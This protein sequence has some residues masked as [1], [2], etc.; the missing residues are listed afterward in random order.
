MLQLLLSFFY[1]G[2]SYRKKFGGLILFH[3]QNCLH[4]CRLKAGFIRHGCRLPAGFIRHGFRRFIAGR[5]RLGFDIGSLSF[6]RVRH[7]FELKN[8]ASE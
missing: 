2:V 7:F 5:F 8:R 6:F 1:E 3:R 4:G